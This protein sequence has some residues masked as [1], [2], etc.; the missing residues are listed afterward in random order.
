M[1]RAGRFGRESVLDG[2]LTEHGHQLAAK[3]GPRFDEQSLAAG[4]E[5]VAECLGHFEEPVFEQL[6]GAGLQFVKDVAAH[7]EDVLAIVLAQG[8]LDGA[9]QRVQRPR[10]FFARNLAEQGAS[11]IKH[12][13]RDVAAGE[14]QRDSAQ[15]GARNPQGDGQGEGAAAHVQHMPP[16]ALFGGGQVER[17]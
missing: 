5:T 8:V 10:A 3:A 14:R 6:V 4:G 16:G 12:V 11:D 7:D 17:G 15:F 13:G 2:C 1:M 9:P